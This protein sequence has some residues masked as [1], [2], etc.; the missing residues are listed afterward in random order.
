VVFEV[1]LEE[2]IKNV[3]RVNRGS[4]SFEQHCRLPQ[5]KAVEASFV[6]IQKQKQSHEVPGPRLAEAITQSEAS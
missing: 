5:S 2:S 1:Y 6:I 3:V 4:D